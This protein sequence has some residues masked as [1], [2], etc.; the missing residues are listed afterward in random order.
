V[1]PPQLAPR[2]R[3]AGSTPSEGTEEFSRS[4]RRVIRG[5]PGLSL[6][7]SS[8]APHLRLQ[9]HDAFLGRVRRAH[10]ST[11][12]CGRGFARTSKNRA[13]PQ[14]FGSRP[15]AP[16]PS[17]LRGLAATAGSVRIVVVRLADERPGCPQSS[18]V[19]NPGANVVV[20]PT[21]RDHAHDTGVTSAK[22][23]RRASIVLA[24]SAGGGRPRSYLPPR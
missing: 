14:G 7:P 21:P 6:L 23:L 1:N 24:V 17:S 9:G 18:P 2:R 20:R 15:P 8:N 19:T 16:W 4:Y 12:S 11:L 22:E 10:G 5:L 3:V 13:E